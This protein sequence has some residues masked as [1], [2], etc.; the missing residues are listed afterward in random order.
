[1]TRLFNP[2][3]KY[4]GDLCAVA[5]GDLPAENR[6]DVEHHLET[7]ADCQRYRDEIGSVTALLAAGGKRF[8]SVEP[9]EIAQRRW[10]RDF[11]AAVKPGPSIATRVFCRFLDWSR[12][13]VWPC[14][15]IWAGL[16]A[17]WVVILGLNASTRAKEE[18][19]TSHRPSPEIMRALLAREGFLPGPSRAADDRE[20]EPPRL[21]SPRPRSEQHGVIKG[22]LSFD[23]RPPLPGPLL[24]RRRGN[25]VRGKPA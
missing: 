9:R 18:V 7:C 4:R 21:P 14:R 10:A 17:I 6:A 1:M 16:A 25:P 8:S 24:Q 3:R 20:A 15:R 11:E 13:L 12:D 22:G 19:R 5:S 2:C 23:V